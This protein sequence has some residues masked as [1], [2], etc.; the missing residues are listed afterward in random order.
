MNRSTLLGA[1]V[2]LS[3][4]CAQGE[5][6]LAQQPIINGTDVDPDDDPFLAVGSLAFD[7]NDGRFFSTCTGTLVSPKFFLTAAHCV[8]G[9][10]PDDRKILFG[11]SDNQT[12][13]DADQII[14]VVEI[15]QIFAS[16]RFNIN[17]LGA[18]NDIAVIH[19]AEEV[20]DIEPIPFNDELLTNADIGREFIAVGFGTTDPGSNPPNS[21]TGGGLKRFVELTLTGLDSQL[22]FYGD[23]AQANVCFGDS[24]GPDIMEFEDGPRVIGVHSFVTFP[25]CHSDSASQRTDVQAESFLNGI[26]NSSVLPEPPHFGQD[27]VCE[28]A[29]RAV[30]PDC[31]CKTDNF[32]DGSCRFINGVPDPD[33]VQEV[34]ESCS[35][36]EPTSNS[37][38]PLALLG[39]GFL[40]FVLF[41]R[42]RSKS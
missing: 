28:A 36:Q 2:S 13:A 33:C 27:G 41:A 39:L 7:F 8:Q 22:T 34:V 30:D 9:L 21:A 38:A 32:C 11:T 19:L 4:S 1:F 29:G 25:S 35:I 37:K 24:G 16:P 42:R 17:N 18:G 26:I 5:L 31:Q 12:G 10:Q 20:T 6:E 23:G 3:L 14:K 40:G 15:D